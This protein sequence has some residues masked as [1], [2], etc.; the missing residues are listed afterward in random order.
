MRYLDEFQQQPLVVGLLR[1]IRVNQ[2]QPIRIME[3]CGSH[4]VAIF[5]HGIRELLPSN[6]V[7]ISGPGCPVCVTPVEEI[8]LALMLA[9][10]P[11]VMLASL[12]DLMR[13]PG[14]WG[15]LEQAMAQGAAVKAVYSSEEGL[16]LARRFPDKQV[17]L[18]AIGFETT[19]APVAA[20]VL[21][22]VQQRVPNFSLLVSHKLIPPAMRAILESEEVNLDGFI[23]P[24]HVSCIIGARAYEFISDQY[25]LP[26]VI[27][28]FEPT[29]ILLGIL[30]ITEQLAGT[31][32][33]VEIQ[34]RRGV[35]YEGNR[36]AQQLISRVFEVHATNWRG[37][38]V[39]P[40]SGWR[41]RPEFASFDARLR[42]TLP[43]LEGKETPGCS[44]GEILRGV[45]IPP[46]C[47]LFGGSCTP[48]MPLGPCMVSG[49]GS[50]AIY[51]RYRQ[52]QVAV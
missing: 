48:E 35:S 23:C 47:S 14:S 20:T 26:A 28:G 21:R 18:L 33:R 27:C 11:G 43:Q 32:R 16:Q 51:Y 34:Y 10:Q 2:Q 22:A 9:Q 12:G 17:V 13:V 39:I 25:H 52:A 3:V 41:L 37:L 46:D 49:E 24:G 44:C 4:T 29:D 19:T 50:C 5:R 6:I 38:G 15:R 42:F 7:L 1:R 36:L 31:S 30:S 45:K 8:D 40:D